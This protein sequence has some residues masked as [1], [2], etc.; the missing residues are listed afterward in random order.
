MSR[1]SLS[2]QPVSPG[3]GTK[4]P[5]RRGAFEENLNE[6]APAYMYASP[7]KPYWCYRMLHEF[8][9]PTTLGILIL[10]Y[11]TVLQSG[12]FTPKHWPWTCFQSKKRHANLDVF[13]DANFLRP[14]VVDRR[15]TTASKCSCIACA[16][17]EH[18]FFVRRPSPCCAQADEAL[19]SRWL[20][21]HICFNPGPITKLLN[22]KLYIRSLKL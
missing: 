12:R 6:V 10:Q 22:L 20:G 3:I 13:C 17:F 19:V 8:M 5:D 21:M 1:C 11:A 9:D 15:S 18:V 14:E 16:V 2:H 7:N 4:S